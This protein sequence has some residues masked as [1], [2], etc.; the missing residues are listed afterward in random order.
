M[1]QKIEKSKCVIGW[2][3][4]IGSRKNLAATHIIYNGKPICGFYL[5]KRADLDVVSFTMDMSKVECKTCK[6]V[7]RKSERDNWNNY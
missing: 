4:I 3:T 1:K 5:N 6:K 7:W 2:Y